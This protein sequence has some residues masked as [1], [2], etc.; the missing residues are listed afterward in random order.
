MRNKK[1]NTL[2]N[3]LLPIITILVIFLIWFLASWIVGDDIILATPIDT[4]KH[5]FL[6]FGD[7]HFW[8]SL[9]GTL[10][11]SIVA[12]VL[13]FVLAFVF[14]FI[15]R[16]NK[17]CKT[18]VKILISI[19]RALPTIAII[20]LLLLWTTSKIAAIVVTM[21][22]VLP[23][24]Y[25]SIMLAFDNLDPEIIEMC[26][27]YKVSKKQ[28]FFKY[29]LPQTTP[30]IID[31]IGG[32]LSLNIK[33]IVASEVIAGTAISIG[34]MMN[35][36]KIYFET[37]NLFALVLITII[38]SVTIEFVFGVIANIYRGRHGFRKHK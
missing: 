36:S 31:T 38:V 13:S 28:Q 11:R 9:G 33:L 27:I 12:F 24:I 6:L 30:S 2:L 10:I 35:E 26:N 4:I 19:L 34:Q 32:G 23:T 25:S 8:K 1:I 18:V 20:L 22:V 16:I 21:I 17:R 7:S 5:G 3:I 14:A 15:S 29:T 37:A